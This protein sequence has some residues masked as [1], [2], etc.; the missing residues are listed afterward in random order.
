MIFAIGM[1][2]TTVNSSADEAL[3][4][5][6]VGSDW[7]EIPEID[8]GSGSLTC[9]VRMEDGSI[10]EVYDTPSL[11]SRKKTSRTTPFQL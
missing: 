7:Q 4:Y 9:Q 8:C 2:F 11:S 3:D 5:I 6:R 1:S 10:H